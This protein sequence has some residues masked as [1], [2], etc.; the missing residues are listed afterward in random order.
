MQIAGE[1]FRL[2]E[3]RE[4]GLRYVDDHMEVSGLD[5]GL[6]G[7]HQ[8]RNAAVAISLVRTLPE[9]CAPPMLYAQGSSR[10]ST[11]VAWSGW[12]MTSSSTVPTM[13]PVPSHWLRTSG[14]FRTMAD[15]GPCF[16]E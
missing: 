13:M 11:R 9:R 2:A 10:R 4:A 3:E 6:E 16:S 8:V 12:P 5:I 1:D 14:G 15:G 7:A